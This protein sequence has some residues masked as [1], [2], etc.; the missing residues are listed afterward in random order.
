[1]TTVGLLLVFFVWLVVRSREVSEFSDTQL[2][3]A[4]FLLFVGLSLFIAGV[5]AAIGRWWLL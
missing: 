3:V 2:Q 4:T 1:M 5:V